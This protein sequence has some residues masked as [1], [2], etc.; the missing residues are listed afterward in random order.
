MHRSN[1]Q[2]AEELKAL[3]AE[4]SCW[5]RCQVSGLSRLCVHAAVCGC[6]LQRL[7][8]C[9]GDLCTMQGL[10]WA[11]VQREPMPSRL[12]SMSRQRMQRTEMPG[13]LLPMNC[14]AVQN[15]ASGSWT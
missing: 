15:H 13:L 3:R 2:L 6:E 1:R 5:T 7:V 12:A 11:L 10:G 14:V 8:G 9:A 4:V